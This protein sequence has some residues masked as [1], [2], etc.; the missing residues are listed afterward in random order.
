MELKGEQFIPLTRDRVWAGLTDSKT[1]Q[2]A[3][4][5]CESVVD[6]GQGRMSVALMAAIGP[7]KARFKGQ[8]QMRDVQAPERYTLSF[9][10]HGGIAGF[11]N[12]QADVVLHSEGDG[13]RM[14]YAAKAHIGGRLAQ[15]GSR[16]V[17]AAA[18]HMTGQ[19]LDRLVQAIEKSEAMAEAGIASEAPGHD[20]AAKAGLGHRPH[21]AIAP[22]RP[23]VTL[24]MPAW[25]WSFTVVV[26]ALTVAYVVTR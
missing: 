24:Q 10:G 5:G 9:E 2:A 26:V 25:T 7:V 12:G 16:L 15:I 8:L 23:L 3:I 1:L 18:A 6:E 13:T 17:D 19:F 22:S 14:S 21:E 11:A 4:P 20:L